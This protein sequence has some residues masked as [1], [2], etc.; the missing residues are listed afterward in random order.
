M[1]MMSSLFVLVYLSL[2]FQ[3]NHV[4]KHLE[5]QQGDCTA[6]LKRIKLFLDFEE[7]AWQKRFSVDLVQESRNL[8]HRVENLTKLRGKLVEAREGLQQALAIQDPLLLL[9]V[10]CTTLS[11]TIIKALH[12]ASYE[13]MHYF[14]RMLL[15]SYCYIVH[16]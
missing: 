15:L 1:C 10:T 5:D 3:T 12:I 13:I 9:Q 2:P 4:Q 8:K 14:I 16:L 11:I 6:F 7:Q